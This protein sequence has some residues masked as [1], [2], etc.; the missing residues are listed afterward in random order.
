MCCARIN[1][2]GTCLDVMCRARFAATAS[3][4]DVERGSGMADGREFSGASR[5]SPALRSARTNSLRRKGGARSLPWSLPRRSHDQNPSARCEATAKRTY[6]HC[7][8]GSIDLPPALMTNLKSW[9][10]L[11]MNSRQNDIYPTGTHHKDNNILMKQRHTR[12]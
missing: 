1:R 4:A 12:V 2:N 7:V 3:C 9:A 10:C 8:C 11:T 5:R 6:H